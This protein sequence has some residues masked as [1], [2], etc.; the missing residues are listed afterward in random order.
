MRLTDLSIRQLKAPDKG[1]KTYFD[2]GLPGF[3]VRVS[4]GGSKSFVV[5]Y[6][7]KR[8]LKTVGRYPHLSLAD[9]RREAKRVQADMLDMQFPTS[10]LDKISFAEARERFLYD[11]QNRNKERTHS[12]Y[13]RLL[14]RHFAFTQNVGDLSRNDIMNVIEKLAATP[15]E[16]QHAF[17]AIRIMMNWCV[18]R[19]IIETSPVPPLSFKAPARSHILSDADLAEVWQGA[20]KLG[21]PYGHITQL[22]ILTGQRRGEVAAIRRSWIEDDLVIFP[23]GF[24]KNKR[25]HRL[26]LSPMAQA[27]LKSLPEIGDLYF[28]ARGTSER[29]FNGWGKSKVKLDAHLDVQPY[30][31]HDLRRTFSSNMARIGTPIHVTEKLLNHVSGTISG[32]AAVYNRY[33][34]MDEMNDAVSRHDEFLAKI[35]SGC[36]SFCR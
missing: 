28:P 32:V 35:V 16:Q 3:G 2:V 24:T 15:S 26:P 7:Q 34:Y 11:S 27:L 12:D 14:H 20:V 9:A 33:S 25:E 36:N 10:T 5:M 13:H 1:Q 23:A 19:G 21:Y 17:V 8:R 30:T 18:K 29:P 4:Q 6:G 22:L 31:L